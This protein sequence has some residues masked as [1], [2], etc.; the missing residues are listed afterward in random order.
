MYIISDMIMPHYGIYLVKLNFML[1]EQCKELIGTF[2]DGVTNLTITKSLNIQ[3]S[4]E[5]AICYAKALTLLIE[6]GTSCVFLHC[7][8]KK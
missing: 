8:E 5:T 3:S 2:C 7:K 4:T 6:R 1:T